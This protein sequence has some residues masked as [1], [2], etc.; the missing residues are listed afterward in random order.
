MD[1][2]FLAEGFESSKVNPLDID[3]VFFRL[4]L[5]RFCYSGTLRSSLDA[6]NLPR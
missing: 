3:Q 6:A 2:R 4:A 1:G 5:A